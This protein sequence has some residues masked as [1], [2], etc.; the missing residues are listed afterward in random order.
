MVRSFAL[1]LLTAALAPLA[2]AA[3]IT[4]KAV[5]IKFEPNN[6]K[7][8]KGDKITFKFGDGNHSV[9]QSSLDDPCAPLSG[10]FFSGYQPS[11]TDSKVRLLSTRL[12]LGK[13]ITGG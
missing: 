8:S 4:V 2:S 3:D 11:A 10:G 5:N 12:L 6:L 7:A 13:Y 1:L 9:V